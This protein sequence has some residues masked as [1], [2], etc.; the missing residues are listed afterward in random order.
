MVCRSISVKAANFTGDEAMVTEKG[1]VEK[2]EK[3][4]GSKDGLQMR[5]IAE[6]GGKWTVYMG[7]KWFIE[8]QKIKFKKATRSKFTAR[9]L[10]EPL[11]QRKSARVTGP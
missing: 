8:N 2:I 3:M 4:Y 7:P 5:L 1:T 11:L 9:R 10:A 6:E